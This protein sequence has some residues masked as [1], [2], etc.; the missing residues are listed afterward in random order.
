MKKTL[1]ILL[2]LIIIIFGVLIAVMIVGS[3]QPPEKKEEIETLPLVETYK[4][5]LKD[6]H[7]AIHSFGVVKPKHQT[8]LVS[9]VSGRLI[10]IA[11]LFVSGGVV[12]KGAVLAT[13]DPSD[14]QAALLDAEANLQR[15]KAALQEEQARGKVAKQ[16]WQ[17]ATSSLPP[18]LGLRKPQLAR[19][20][21]N[22]RSAQAMLA[23]AKRNLERTII[24]AP[25]DALINKRSADLGQFVSMG[26]PL[27]MVSSINIAE[28]RLPIS[29][30]DYAFVNLDKSNQVTLTRK[31]NGHILTWQ[32][33]IVRDEG[34][35]DQNSRMIYLVAQIDKPYKQQHALKFGS[36]I[37]ATI[38]SHTVNQIAAIPSYLYRDGKI[39]L[40]DD[41]NAIKQQSVTL[42]R[43]D[44]NFVYISAGL[45]HGD[46][47]AVTKMEHLFDGMK[48]RLTSDEL[49]DEKT[50][51]TQLANAGDE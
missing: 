5:S 1:R 11:P 46:L 8:N 34:V 22:L 14:Y 36:F 10:D 51:E 40:V 15:A 6:Q 39:T 16:E 17:G 49:S 24:R 29:M 37:E 7:L 4:V 26:T 47:I 2:P 50:G 28:I 18:E 35:I 30:A 27:G 3:K 23:R 20:Q 33:T 38:N 44:K 41:N 9:E 48:V 45:Q 42:L 19:E 31:E 43:R 25:Y 12:K 32:A 13:I 21:A